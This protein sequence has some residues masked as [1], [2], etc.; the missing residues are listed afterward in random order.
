MKAFLRRNRWP[1]TIGVA[2]L[3]AALFAPLLSPAAAAATDSREKLLEVERTLDQ[4][5]T[6]RQRMERT[7][8]VYADDRATLKRRLVAAARRAQDHEAK[9][10]DLERRIA[11]LHQQDRD[12]LEGRRTDTKN[13]ATKRTTTTVIR[14]SIEKGIQKAIR[15]SV[16]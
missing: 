14:L 2:V 12:K 11:A 9:I 6:R 10:S 4:E 7:A 15:R 3:S 13:G 1:S 8:E 16:R 5:R